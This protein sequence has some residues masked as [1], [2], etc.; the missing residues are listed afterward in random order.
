M[1]QI[2]WK[3]FGLLALLIAAGVVLICLGH[4]E[5]GGTMTGAFVLIALALCGVKKKE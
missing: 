4:P 2:G 3:T 5:V 1:I